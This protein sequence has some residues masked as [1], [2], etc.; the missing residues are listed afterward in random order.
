MCRPHVFV[1]AAV[2]LLCYSPVWA[3]DWPQF[4]SD[5]SRSGYTPDPLPAGLAPLWTYR[6]L[7]PPA[8]A[9]LGPDTRMPFDHASQVVVASGLVYFGSSADCRL[10]AL[11]AATGQERW[12]Y[13]TDAPIRF[14]P[15]VW[16]DRVF[17]AGDD[18]MLHC[19]DAANGRLL[20]RKR[21]APG[22]DWV[23]GNGRII[24]RW[25]ARG[26]LAIRDGILYVAA[27]IWPSEGIVV[28]ALR[29]ATGDLVWENDSA[30][31]VEMDQPHGTA[32]AKSGISA[33]GYLTLSGDTL[34]VP[35]GRATPAALSLTDGSLRHFRLQE[36]SGRGAGPFISAVGQWY[37][38]ELDAFR[39]RDGQRFSRGIPSAAM[40]ATPGG[41]VHVAPQGVA[42]TP[43]SQVFV[44]KD[45]VDRRGAPTK[46]YVPGEPTW[47]VSCPGPPGRCLIAAG[48]TAAV[49]VPADAANGGDRVVLIDTGARKV[50]GSLNVDG[51]PLGLAAA[52]GRLY[53]STDKGVIQCFA[54]GPGEP[55]PP[56]RAPARPE[57]AAEGPYAAAAD[58]ILRTTG[59]TKG[60][61]VD[62]ACGDAGL[63]RELALR[64]RLQLIAV[65]R[66]ASAAAAAREALT[67]EGLYGTRVTVLCRDPR[68]TH[69]PNKLAN[70][71]VSGESVRTGLA[72][73]TAAELGRLQRPYGGV[74]CMGKPGAMSTAVSGAPSGAGEW[75]HQYAT[76]G[77]LGASQDEVVQGPLGMLWFADNTFQMPSRHGRGPSPLFWNGMLFV[78]GVDGLRAI[79]AYNGTTLWEYSLPGILK[80]YDQEHLN[81][82]AV[83]GSNICLAHGC[84]YVRLENRCLRLD[85]MSGELLSTFVAPTG[86]DGQVHKWGY[87]ACDD[88]L[89]VGSLYNETHQVDFAFGKSDMSGLYSESLMLF[90]MDA[91]TGELRWT[92][93]P[94]ASIRNNAIAVGGGRVFLIDRSIAVRDRAKG[95]NTEH[96]LGKLLALDAL[97]GKTAWTEADPAF[98]TMLAVSEEHDVLLMSYQATRFAVGSEVGGRLAAFRTSDGTP[99]WNV[100]ASYASRPLIVGRTIYAQP[101]AWD[102]LTGARQDFS[103]SR[104]YG[105]GTLAGSR[106]LLAFRSA[107]LGY[108]DLTEDVGT[109]NYGGIRPGCW[110]N[111]LPVGGL[112]LLPEASNRCVCSYLIKASC[113]L[114][115]YGLRAPRIDPPSA[116]S[117]LPVTVRLSAVP[118]GGEVRYTLDGSTPRADSPPYRGPLT[119]SRTCTLTA[120]V[121][122]EGIRGPVSSGSFTVDR[123]MIPLSGPNWRVHDTPGAGP[124][125][126]NW[127]V[128]DGVAAEMSNH[129]RGAAADT[130]IETERPG[131][132]REYVPAAGATDGEL[133]FDVACDDDD[134]LGMALRFTDPQHYYLWAMDS[135][136]AFRILALKD[137]DRYAVLARN[138]KGYTRGKWYH[139]R[140]VLRGAQIRVEVDGEL[141]LEITD[142]TLPSGTFAL[143]S[144]GST[145]ARFR[146]LRWHAAG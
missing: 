61:C 66:D 6:P 100:E 24:S 107:T 135:Q 83:T 87:L 131:T 12:S 74:V 19:L 117:N 121:V 84:L 127:V 72:P 57:P 10:R 142:A 92:H 115:P 81:G 123:D 86:P 28:Q 108:R 5:A 37:F 70:L 3:R 11:D 101:G 136:R 122:R 113:A 63:A 13:C 54:A 41:I 106:S 52:D 26:G 85:A 16:Q 137:G 129:F 1:L 39:L 42:Q 25:P 69:L 58:E 111:A 50:T 99:L 71:I 78:E 103:F 33:Q 79:D 29:A 133:S 45:T 68:D 80:A 104:S 30:G 38:C 130:N 146:N 120:R 138:A 109:E 96:P 98:G 82:V 67:N 132:Y 15:A 47:T 110:I 97:T 9:W 46:Q 144:W 145:G 60:Y 119:I 48:D 141:D 56:T 116:S 93:T 77:N 35:T 8:P 27:G 14:A 4:R 59:V 75:T 124:P 114:Q 76:P 34:L 40:A 32:R 89:L 128:T 17:C 49:G 23:L 125:Q 53:A 94:Q 64:S 36:Y 43:L 140:I 112:L 73:S 126:S 55:A 7:Q 51:V 62:L 44:E 105:C 143:Y 21:V 20:W 91:R 118:P 102:L 18:G 134:G 90:G 65:T 95:D 2:L 22:D 139:V 31:Y 88:G